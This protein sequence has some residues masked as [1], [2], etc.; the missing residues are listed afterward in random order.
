MKPDARPIADRKTNLCGPLMAGAGLVCCALLLSFFGCTA[1]KRY[2]TL[3][4]FFDGVPDPNAPPV[5]AEDSEFGGSIGRGKG[6]SAVAYVHKPYAENKCEECH[7]STGKKFED[8]QKPDP[9]LCIKCH[10]KE[11]TRYPVMH[12]PVAVAECQLC[13]APH[14]STIK[15]MLK[16]PSPQV[17]VQCHVTE[18][19]LP[20]PP[21][22]MQ[23]DKSC[24]DCHVAHGAEK[25]GLLRK[26]FALLNLAKPA[27]TNTAPAPPF[28]VAP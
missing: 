14:E 15:G 8:F 21:E 13:H 25:H 27:T 2:K 22:H 1:E 4:F 16:Q 12:G 18:L 7:A 10:Q 19:L 11:L 9:L 24:L 3:S 5:S 23:A 17:C 28:E 6:T 20:D 26:D